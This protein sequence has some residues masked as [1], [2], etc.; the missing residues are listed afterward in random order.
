MYITAQYYLA[1]AAVITYFKKSPDTY[2]V[3]KFYAIKLLIC[4]N[5]MLSINT[6][7]LVPPRPQ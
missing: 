7:K 4:N 3:I 2:T 6:F 5:F 1:R